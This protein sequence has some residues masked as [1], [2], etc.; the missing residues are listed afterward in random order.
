MTQ[1]IKCIIEHQQKGSNKI[2]NTQWEET[3]LCAN[4]L[5]MYETPVHMYSQTKAY[6][7]TQDTCKDTC[8]HISGSHKHI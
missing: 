2:G 7:L 6:L 1:N 8:K 3:T 4:N 5:Y